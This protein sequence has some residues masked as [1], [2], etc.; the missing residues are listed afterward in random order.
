MVV[1]LV[2]ITLQHN[3]FCSPTWNT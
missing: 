2:E 1:L 3:Q